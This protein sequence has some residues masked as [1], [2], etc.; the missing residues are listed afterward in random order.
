MSVRGKGNWWWRYLP[1]MIAK[2]ASTVH[3]IEKSAI[4]QDKS[5]ELKSVCSKMTSRMRDTTQ[6]LR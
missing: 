1:E 5:N 6:T 4:D 3:H 2:Q